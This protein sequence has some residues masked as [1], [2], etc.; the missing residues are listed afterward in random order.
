MNSQLF[1]AELEAAEEQEKITQQETAARARELEA[2][3]KDIKGHRE[4][5]FKKAEESLKRAKKNA[6]ECS[7]RWKQRE[8][9]FEAMR[10]EVAELEAAAAASTQGPGR[11][12]PRGRRPAARPAR[13]AGPPPAG[14]RLVPAYLHRLHH[15]HH[16]HYLHY[17]PAC[18][19][20]RLDAIIV[21]H[22]VTEALFLQEDVKQ[23]QARI[24]KHKEEISR[25]SGAIARLV[26]NKKQLVDANAEMELKIKE[27]DCKVKEAQ[28]EATDTV[29]MKQYFGAAGGAYDFSGG[30]PDA[31]RLAALSER[32]A[33]LGRGLNARAHT[34]LHKED[35]QYQDVM[36]KKRIV[37]SDRAKLVQVMGELDEKKRQTLVAACQQVNRDF[38]SIFS[39]L[40][41]GAAARLRPPAGRHVLDGLEINVGFNDTWKES[42]GEL[43]GGQRSL[44]ALSLVLA[45]L[46]FKPA[47]L[48]ILDEVD[49]ALDLSHTQN[50]GLMLRNHFRHSQFL[51]VSL[52]DGMFN[53]ANVL[54]RTRFVDGM[55][56]VQRS[57]NSSR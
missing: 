1:V 21:R 17:L 13:R 45:M 37:E 23:Y 49:A 33:R 36:R 57:V 46:L 15:L 41:P 11:L 27:L 5:E 24:K 50:I 16:L 22:P 7:S 29:K 51:I 32:R 35:E 34:L 3:V 52:K 53:N 19:P 56:S 10:L 14:P 20:A 42:L 31:G 47:P 28:T 38:G 26:G 54:F 48:Y 40:L 12:R 4:R 39:A 2:K 43:S 30:A 6:E 8:Q 44:V 9:E 55:S 18:P 25:G